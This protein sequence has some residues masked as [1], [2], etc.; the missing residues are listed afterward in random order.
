VDFD[1]SL[2]LTGNWHL[3]TG[4]FCTDL[5]PELRAQ[6]D[7]LGLS[8]VRAAS[9]SERALFAPALAVYQSVGATMKALYALL[10]KDECTCDAPLPANSPDAPVCRDHHAGRD[11]LECCKCCNSIGSHSSRRFFFFFAMNQDFQKYVKWVEDV[12][13]AYDMMSGSIDEVCS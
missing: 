8:L 12:S 7:A 11:S 5:D 3:R 10:L 13:S 9:P 4:M 6:M 2:F 1:C